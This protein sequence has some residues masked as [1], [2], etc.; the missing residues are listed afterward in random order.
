MEFDTNRVRVG[1]RIGFSVWLVSSHAH[2]FIILSV[3]IAPYPFPQQNNRKF[4]TWYQSLVS[5]VYNGLW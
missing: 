4:A 5:Y 1:V 3:V 2:V